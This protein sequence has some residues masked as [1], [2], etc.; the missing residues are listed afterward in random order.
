MTWNWQQKNWPEFSFDREALA[1]LEAKFLHQSGVLIGALKS[2]SDDD[3]RALTIE[4][5]TDE[6]L[7][8]SAIEGEILDRDSVQSSIA[9]NFGLDTPRR[10]I[11]SAEKGIAEMMVDLYRSYNTPLSHEMLFS[12]HMMLLTGRSD[13]RDIG[14]YRTHKEAMRVVSGKYQEPI[15]HFEAPPSSDIKMEMG[16]FIEWF[17]TGNTSGTLTRA[18][19]AHL[20]F[21]SIHPFE[22][23]NG[24]LG[25]A[26]SEKSLSMSLGRPTLISLSYMIEKHRKNY[27]RALELNNK[28]LEITDWLLYF[29]RT[30]LDAQGYTQS[31]INF[32]IEKTR[33]YDRLRGRLNER[34]EKVIARMFREGVDGFKGGLS[35]ENYI[36]IADTSRATATRDL[37]DLVDKGALWKKGQLKHTRYYLNIEHESATPL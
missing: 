33:L 35:A 16:R 10:G 17:N 32:L 7:T 20:Y 6:A 15:I 23:G 36:R 21:V 1:Y 9:R 31:L 11:P 4:I 3:K 5:I 8:T 14:R 37:R 22:D 29:A 12:W 34:Q 26:I 13:L 19:V 2:F 18:G 27:Y 25:R 28:K 24:R 30:I